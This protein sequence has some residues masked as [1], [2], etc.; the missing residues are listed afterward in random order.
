MLE[1]GIKHTQELVMDWINQ[2]DIKFLE[3]FDLRVVDNPLT[4]LKK[5]SVA[6][7]KTIILN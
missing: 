6:E 4:I 3:L 1:N 5:G 2:V 7:R